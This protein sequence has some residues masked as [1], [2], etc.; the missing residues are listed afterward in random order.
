MGFRV[1]F[2]KGNLKGL[3]L[4]VFW[5]YGGVYRVINYFGFKVLKG[6]LD[7][8]FLVFIGIVL[9]ERG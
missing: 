8:R 9:G 1:F 4:F 2:I 6:F 5:G 3:I 7:V